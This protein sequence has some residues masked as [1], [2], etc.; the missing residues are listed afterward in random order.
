MEAG[1]LEGKMKRARGFGRGLARVRQ[2][3]GAFSADGG[4]REDR[5]STS[6]SLG[7]R[8][9]RSRSSRA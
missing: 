3:V 5:E 8:L 2:L 1:Q 7:A 4:A 6:V 9:T